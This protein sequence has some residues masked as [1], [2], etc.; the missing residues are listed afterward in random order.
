VIIQPPLRSRGGARPNGM[1]VGD[2]Q[3]EDDRDY[4]ARMASFQ[5]AQ[6]G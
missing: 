3:P 6:R 5:V 2:M 1:P 4:A